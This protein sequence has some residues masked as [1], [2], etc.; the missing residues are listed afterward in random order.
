MCIPHLLEA[1]AERIPNA[2]AI[3]APGRTSLTYGRLWIHINN[4][5]KTLHAT[6]V[7]RNDRVALVLPNGP[8]MAVA[9]LAVAASATS[10]PL[11]PAYCAHEFDFYLS[12]LNPTLLII[13]SGMDSPARA[14]A[15]AR[16]IS[17]LE[18]SPV[19]E[20]EAGIFMLRDH[21]GASCA[22]RCGLAQPDDVALVLH[23][24]GTTSQP[25]IVP[26]THTNICSSAY[27]YSVTFELTQSDLCL[28]VMP[29][30]H[31]HGLIGVVLSSLL[32]GASVV[33]TPGFY[34]LQFFAWM[35]EFQPT[36]YTA[37][38]T[39]HQAILVRAASSRGIIE[40]LS[41]RF[42]RSGSAPLPL[43]VL[44]ALE[45]VFNVP[46]IEVYG[47]TES[48]ALIT[49]NPLP[50]RVRKAGSVGVAAGPEVAIMDEAGNLLPSGE[51]GE[52]VLRGA[53]IMQGYENDPTA[54][55]AAFINGWFRTGDQGFLDPDGYLFITGR[56]K[57]LI[58]CGGEKISPHEVEEVL[59][60]HPAVA[61]VVA[62][63]IPHAQ[64]GEEVAVLVVRANVAV[65][66]REIRA[67]A[68]ARL[69]AFKVPRQ[70]VF[71]NELPQGATGKVQRLG[72]AERLGLLETGQ[73]QP[74]VKA[75]FTASHTVIE[76]TLAGIWTQVL[77]L[78]RVGIHDNYFELGGDSVLAT[79]LLSRVR[80]VMQVALPLVSLFEAPTIAALARTIETARDGVQSRPFLPLRPII[81]DSNLPLSHTQQLLWFFEQ[82]E[83]GSTAYN[84][85]IAFH[86]RGL[87]NVPALEQSLREI[88]RRHNILRTTFPAID[89]QPVQAIPSD[90]DWRLQIVDLQALPNSERESEAR[91]QAT[92]AA[93]HPFDLTRGPLLR[94]ILLRLA[95][96]EQLFLLTIHHIIFDGWSCEVFFRELAA[97]YVAFSSGKPVLLPDLP[98]Q[99]ADFVYW[100]RQQMQGEILERHL[101]YWK[102][103]LE[104]SPSILELPI[105]RPRPPHQTFRGARQSFVLSQHL[106][107]AL[108]VLGQQEGATLF[109]TLVA[110]F[111]A[112]LYRYTG[113]DDIIIGS[114]TAGRDRME[115]EGLVGFFVHTLVLR[116]N[117]KEDP[118]FREI[119]KR[120][121][122]V[123]LRAYAHQE[124]PFE[125]IISTLQPEHDRSRSP[126]MHV[127]FN[128]LNFPRPCLAL[129][130]LTLSRIAI[131]NDEMA[132]FDLTLYVAEVSQELTIT[133]NYNA[134]L[135]EALTITQMLGHFQT[136]LNG[137]VTD[138]GQRLSTLPLLTSDERQHLVTQ[139]QHVR[140]TNPFTVFPKE[141]IEQS[142]TDR[143]VKQVQRFPHNIAV[144]TKHEAWTYE[145]L[146]RKA[147]SVAQLLLRMH[148]AGEERIALLFD[149]DASMIAALLGVLKIGKIYIPLEPA[150][151]EA[152]LAYML[153][154]SQA[155]IILT[156]TKNI[157]IAQ[158][159]VQDG[160]QIINLDEV[161]VEESCDDPSLS[162]SPD[163]LAYLLYTSGSTGQPKGVI[164]NHRNVLHHIRVY[165]NN[166]HICTEDR[167]TLLSSY[168][169][170]A[171]VMDI[172]GALLNGATLYPI[173]LKEETVE[174]TVQ[175]CREQEI[176]LYH[177]T[178]TVY[179]YVV[180]SLRTQNALLKLRL[181]VLGGEKVHKR[182]VELYKQHFAPA[183]LL[184]NGLGPT[185]STVTLQYFI[186]H[187]TVI[188]RQAVPVGFPVEDTEIVLLDSE[189]KPTA[190]VGEIAIRSPYIA[191][192]YWRKP[193]LTQAVFLPDPAQGNRRIY[194]TG[195][196]GRFRPD[197]TLEFMG[198][199]DHQVK[200]RGFRIELGEIEAVLGQ[201]PTIR[202]AVVLAREDTRGTT[203]LVAYVVP[204]QGSP[205][206]S[207]A[208]RRF[209][210]QKLPDHMVP[211]AF[212][213]LPAMPFTPN[214]KVDHSRLPTP[215]M[216]DAEFEGAFVAPRTALESLIAQIWQDILSV[217]RV[218]VYDNFFDLGG[219]SLLAMH[220]IGILKEKLKLQIH[221]RELTV[222]TLG[223]LATAC[224][225]RLLPAVSPKPLS[226]TQKFLLALKRMVFLQA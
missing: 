115:L 206:T 36:W 187:H 205:L 99:Y 224:E 147:N 207:S 139:R 106:T 3:A 135:F 156:N 13:Q 226:F 95:A 45:H 4:V 130:G 31:V 192:G 17:I 86:I 164:Q 184:V 174:D 201:H 178:P 158:R 155:S 96:D 81:Q 127:F 9:F 59:L 5:V 44:T 104:G 18:L 152:R 32:A 204:D 16:G 195:D 79:Q 109:M 217:E 203:R 85:S 90:L 123:V 215:P 10:V 63:A 34:A 122:D 94:T 46:V 58:N 92:A 42:I 212:I 167:L 78:E 22:V 6:G 88:V 29:L 169:F 43:Q 129:P 116:T 223:Q 181:I 143:F 213:W 177:S 98:I 82:L 183:C 55:T 120:V 97:L 80:E 180:S 211:S 197:G 25:K 191:L 154:D 216:T 61:Q 185:E 39:M 148:S 208:L 171:A 102:Q 60:K 172:F 51:T 131:D 75:A 76:E 126:L 146:N 220:V 47:L 105:D 33:C 128:F 121:R 111:K 64:L 107:K 132:K 219:H 190:V 28:N 27:N 175:W 35:E 157:F 145:V 194:R 49:S 1:Q 186:D 54:N 173:D 112:L 87:L 133:A 103:Q 11:N 221:P 198:R 119:L 24:S 69:A 188:T 37:A 21:K 176:T 65:T 168:S 52:I 91:R 57:E 77:S 56:L 73:R 2:I 15:Q 141:E 140:P 182:D 41:L 117:L 26:L 199:K 89:G 159:L 163:T 225:E 12:A 200:I 20:A 114:P 74:E 101:D 218:S 23:T 151:P 113:Q 162:V 30:F 93:R 108:K 48:S 214:G 165:T 166:L 38:P 138:A 137:I 118:S 67:F 70:V 125:Q 134:D 196:I 179:R 170:D 142:L 7:G 144:K 150:Y 14:V 189:G 66:D 222:Q 68:A 210:Q 62:F 53:S 100:Q 161:P 124:I 202:Q 71:V 40:R 19:F 8:E 149:H 72:L 209:L 110:A 136:L 50:P 153:Q 84:I 160:Q 83:P 193:E